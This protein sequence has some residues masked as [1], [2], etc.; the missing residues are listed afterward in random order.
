MSNLKKKEAAIQKEQ[1]L[2]DAAKLEKLWSTYD[3]GQEVEEKIFN[4]AEVP[5]P[6]PID[7][8]KYN[9]YKYVDIETFLKH[10]FFLYAVPFPWQLLTL[11]LFYMGTEGNTN[12]TINDASKENTKGC[13]KCVW[14][15]ALD[16]EYENAKANENDLAYQPALDPISSKCLGCSRCPLNL[17]KTRLEYEIEHASQKEIETALKEKLESE[18]ED[19]FQSEM[20]LIESIEDEEIKLQLKNKLNNRFSDL[21]LVIGRRGTKMLSLDTP[22]LTTNGWSTMGDIKIGDYIFAPDGTPTKVI[23]KSE[24]NYTEQAYEIHFSNEDIIEAGE[25]HEWYLLDENNRKNFNYT[26]D[27]DFL[28]GKVLKTKDIYESLKLKNNKKCKFS[29]EIT[30]PINYNHANL[31]V[32]PYFLGVYLSKNSNKK[33]GIDLIQKNY[34][35][36][37]NI[38]RQY[39]ESS[40]EQ[41]MEL[42]RGF[43]DTKGKISNKNSII[44]FTNN[45]SELMNNL[46]ELICG[47]GFNA[48]IT[49]TNKNNFKI[50]FKA[51]PNIKFFNNIK[52]Q[53]ILE[54]NKYQQ[55]WHQ[56]YIK[57]CVPIKNKGCQ[58]IQVDHP[59]HLYLCGK[60]LIPTHN[61]VMT[62]WIALYEIYKL[63]KM[64]HPQKKLGLNSLQEIHVINV[65]NNE[66]QAQDSIFTPMKN[67][68]SSSPFFAGKIGRN[69][70]HELGFLT[71]FDIEEN[72]KRAEKGLPPLEGTIIA[73]CGSS[74]AGG[75]VG[76]TCWAVILD[77]LAAMAGDS[78]NSGLD[79]KLYNELRPSLATFRK[80]GKMICLS[81]PKGPHGMLWKLYNS[82]L[83]DPNALVLRLPSWTINVT[84]S[85]ELLEDEKRKNPIEFNMQYAAEFGS[86][87]AN[88]YF[89]PEDINYAFDNSQQIKRIEER[90]GLYD[91]YCHLDPAKNSDYYALVVVHAVQTQDKDFS[92][93]P[94]YKYFVDHIHYWAPIKMG[95]PVQFNQV[96]EYILKL[97]EKFKFKLITYDQWHSV[98]SLQ[99]LATYR[100]PLQLRVFNNEYKD[101]IYINLFEAFRNKN[102]EFYKISAGK[103]LNNKDQLI[104]INEINEA[105]DQLIFLQ[106]KWRGAR[107]VIG[108][109]GGYKDDIC[110]A[111][112]AAVYEASCS[113]VAK[114]NSLPKSRIAIT[115]RIR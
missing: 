98:E 62:Y 18:P 17:R 33:F 113:N 89:D 19:L 115:G 55:D 64:G 97:N 51:Q 12:V 91:Y 50:S 101:K 100:L 11:K 68:A 60:S 54:K 82:G 20:D 21:T 47:L 66:K 86:N 6:D 35:K 67:A 41:R 48:N 78:P 109:L 26:K 39:L 95:Q 24:I 53:S 108:A 105:K 31:N 83:N 102:I 87:S 8:T 16:N 46:Y 25:S 59:S 63:L 57:K 58:C 103:V 106:K 88:P 36:N 28:I 38:P 13:D 79:E 4:R 77:E 99:K 107:Q 23:T 32:D 42:L 29:I 30:R 80:N 96:E 76:K 114:I 10:P 7:T 85:K 112:A 65:A 71:D 93:K 3:D 74:E 52:K 111:L 49:Q 2:R 81:N 72:K 73:M 15:Y 9:P 75:I 84:L 43:L 61:S 104:D 90:T 22:I 34:L 69:N 92:G 40:Y 1:L 70:K 27:Y 5:E 14:K 94:V 56:V 45:N 44:Y 110:D 37:K